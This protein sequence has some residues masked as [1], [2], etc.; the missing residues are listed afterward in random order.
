MTLEGLTGNNGAGR[1]VGTLLA[2]VGVAAIAAYVGQAAPGARSGFAPSQTLDVEESVDALAANGSRAAFLWDGYSVEVWDVRTGKR[3]DAG[4]SDSG[5]S[6]LTIA[7][8]IVGYLAFEDTLSLHYRSLVTETGFSAFADLGC[9][10]TCLGYV[11]GHGD[12]LVYNSWQ[13]GPR[14][15]EKAVLW[16]IVGKHSV[17]IIRGRGSLYAAAVDGGRIV[18]RSPRLGATL[19]SEAE[20]ILARYRFRQPVR[21]IRLSGPSLAALLPQTIVVVDASTGAL[22]RSWSV[23]KQTRLEDVADG[24]VVYTVRRQIYV[25]RLADGRDTVIPLP[26]NARA[27]VH[28]QLEPSGLFYS[29][30]L[31]L[32]PGDVL[33][34]GR[35]A[36]APMTR[37][38]ALF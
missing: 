14:G 22:K 9:A 18:V 5:I 12:L 33:P 15:I 30:T 13:N 20:S 3:R 36:F 26:N 4:G 38:A 19:V 17:P 16:R 1:W 35:L 21:T 2:A 11:A 25:R 7:G 28:A 24:L 23:P 27:P 10:R 34:H 32:G 29:W 6:D 8:N 37:V 31:P